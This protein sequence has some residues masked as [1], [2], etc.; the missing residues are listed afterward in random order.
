M[1]VTLLGSSGQLARGSGIAIREHVRR[2]DKPYARVMRADASV[3]E[4][5]RSRVPPTPGTPPAG[6]KTELKKGRSVELPVHDFLRFRGR[7]DGPQLYDRLWDTACEAW[8]S[9]KLPRSLAGDP[10]I[11]P[12][13]FL[14]RPRRSSS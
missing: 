11:N 3:Q 12:L 1:A 6:A 2:G 8:H 10:A 13:H 7:C 14:H 4:G 9:T 5:S